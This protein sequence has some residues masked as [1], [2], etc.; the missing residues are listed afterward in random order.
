M[1]KQKF[2]PEA[3]LLWGSVPSQVQ[4][5]ILQN[6]FC[7]KCGGSVT[8]VDYTGKEENGDLILE[9]RCGICGKRVA[10][11][12]ETSEMKFEDN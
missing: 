7:G 4:E 10:R 1:S 12:V 8:I 6:V 9:G 3:E 2:T 11:V 5:R